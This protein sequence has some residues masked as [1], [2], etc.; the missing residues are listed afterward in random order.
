MVPTNI[1]VID[2]DHGNFLD[3][4][5]VA[6]QLLQTTKLNISQLTAIEVVKDLFLINYVSTK[7]NVAKQSS[8]K[9]F[10]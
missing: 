2:M 5:T 3:L 6:N 10:L 8:G 9:L 4:T 7:I 1:K